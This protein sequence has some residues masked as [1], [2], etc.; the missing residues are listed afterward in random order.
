MAKDDDDANTY[1]DLDEVLAGLID[2]HATAKDVANAKTHP[3]SEDAAL[4]ARF[5]DLVAGEADL[6]THAV[7]RM[8]RRAVAA[9]TDEASAG[10]GW[11]NDVLTHAEQA[12][13]D[14]L[15]RLAHEAQTIGDAA[16]RAERVDD[17]RMRGADHFTEQHLSDRESR[18]DRDRLNERAMLAEAMVRQLGAAGHAVA[19]DLR[20]IYLKLPRLV[21]AV[22]LMLAGDA[23]AARRA[24]ASSIVRAMPP[25][26]EQLQSWM[27]EPNCDAAE[28][29]GLALAALLDRKAVAA[30]V[31]VLSKL[32]T[33]VLTVSLQAPLTRIVDLAPDRAA[34]NAR[35]WAPALGERQAT[36]GRVNASNAAPLSTEAVARMRLYAAGIAPLPLAEGRM[37]LAE[38]ARR[39][40]VALAHALQ[41]PGAPKVLEGPRYRIN[42]QI[43]P[44]LAGIGL[45]LAGVENPHR[46]NDRALVRA[47]S[48]VCQQFMADTR[49]TFEMEQRRKIDLIQRKRADEVKGY[50]RDL[51]DVL[52]RL[53][54]ATAALGKL[55]LDESGKPVGRHDEDDEHFAAHTGPALTVTVCPKIETKGYSKAKEAIAGHEHM[56]GL[57]VALA[58]TGDLPEKRRRLC[59][60]FPW[61]GE[62]VDFVLTDLVNRLGV[63][64]RPV[65]LTGTPGSGKT[66]FARRFAAIFGLHVW[67][68]DCGAS[69]GGVFGGTDRRWHSSEPSHPFL[70][71]SRGKQANPLVILDE[72]EKA[73]TRNDY[74]RLWDAL[75]P[76]LEPGCNRAVQDRCLQVAIDGG[77]IN[78]IATANRIDPLP[79]PLRD[80]FRQ[81]A[82][83]EPAA[84]HLDAL[85][86]PLTAEL[87]R[88]RG[89][90]PRFIAPF[91]EDER[92]FLKRGWR[93]GSVRR[94]SRM[95]EAVV[96]ARERAMPIN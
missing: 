84:E 52:Q 46:S 41:P 48:D 65:L 80:R 82:F 50:K 89:L 66:H 87:A 78:Y 10:D 92:A 60:E 64:I 19:D 42:A 74:G 85:V 25:L 16:A 43:E 57:P 31:P 15:L 18:L 95:I 12:A 29:K 39:V 27:E 86:G 11:Q 55:G 1:R 23:R 73:P 21:Q 59:A 30:D 24:A 35:I 81:I 44:V 56:L 72:L 83:P 71:M 32:A 22:L 62:I 88:V 26:A 63:T 79:W 96:N 37:S 33:E 5:A 94:L 34:D 20:E 54:A 53:E 6:F 47:A 7:D 8:Q 75:L 51:D 49:A 67:S 76:F 2:Q 70:A 9:G 36:P 77:H 93:G 17:T 58:P 38:P 4:D 3:S 13:Y 69:D 68:V 45:L 61:A 40:A 90:D 91:D 14:C 28:H